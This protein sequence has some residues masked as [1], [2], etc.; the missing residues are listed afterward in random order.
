MP[1]VTH[2]VV[3]RY[4]STK[5]A[6]EALSELSRSSGW[7]DHVLS[8]LAISRSLQIPEPPPFIAGER[9]G[10][11]LRGETFFRWNQDPDYLPW[12]I[13][14]IAQHLERPFKNDDEAISYVIA[15]WHRGL[16][17]LMADLQE[18]DGVF[19]DAMVAIARSSTEGLADDASD[20]GGD[21]VAV[22]EG[23]ARRCNRP[24]DCRRG[25]TRE[26]YRPSDRYA[27]RF[28]AVQQLPRRC[29][30]NE[31]QRQDPVRQANDRFG[32]FR[33]GRQH[34]SHFH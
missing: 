15:H 29:E 30:R 7:P 16:E 25:E 3:A 6:E 13:A 34:W 5:Q 14:M 22:A 21:H 27:Q 4:K 26:G 24:S 20:V 31:R 19:N 8:R 1:L 33:S 23:T 32:H 2:L 9:K 11:E 17:L 28:E 10:K 12:V 18:F